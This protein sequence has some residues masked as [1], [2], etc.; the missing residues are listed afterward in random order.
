M[1]L[2]YIKLAGF[3]S[4]VDPTTIKFLG[5]LVSIL[6]PNGCGKSNIIDAIRWVM[7]ESSAK[8]LR[9]ESI[10]DVIFNGSATRSPVG[11]ASIELLFDNQQGKITGEFS[12]YNEIS[13]KRVL[14]R[15]GQSLYYL[16]KSRC[17]RK[18]VKE[19]FLGT[20]LGPRS[21][22]I[23]EQGTISR[24]IEAKPEEVRIYIE[25]AAGVSKY[26]ERRKETENRIKQTRENLSRLDDICSELDKQLSRLQRQARTAKN[27]S[28]LKQEERL[29]QAQLSALRWRNYDIELKEQQLLLSQQETAL[30]NK[31]L[32]ANTLEAKI[33]TSHLNLAS[34]NQH[35]N[36]AQGEF[37]QLEADISKL[38]QN[39][40]NLKERQRQQQKSLK[41]AQEN[42]YKTQAHLEEDEQKYL[43]L[44]TE[45]ASI[46]PDFAQAKEQCLSLENEWKKNEQHYISWKNKWQKK[47]QVIQQQTHTLQLEKTNSRHIEQQLEQL[48]NRSNKLNIELSSLSYES[49]KHEIETLTIEIT[50]LDQQLEQHQLELNQQETTLEQLVKQYEQQTTD[51]AQLKQQ[52]QQYQSKL[53]ALEQMQLALSNDNQA[54]AK[55]WLSKQNLWDKQR[56]LQNLEV[57]ENYEELVETVLIDYLQAFYLSSTDYQLVC[58]EL[59][60]LSQTS[61][62][63]LNFNFCLVEN[64]AVLQSQCFANNKIN[65]PRLSEFINAE[66]VA[67]E[68][69]AYIYVASDLSIALA[70]QDFLQINEW[71]ITQDGFCVGHCWLKNIASDPQHNG[72]IQREKDIKQLNQSINS[73][74]EIL[75]Q[76]QLVVAELAENKKNKQQQFKLAQDEL[77]RLQKQKDQHTSTLHSK[78][79]IIEQSKKRVNNINHEQQELTVQIDK[80]QQKQQ[81]L[82]NKIAEIA[83]SLTDLE[84]EKNSLQQ[85]SY[86]NKQQLNE[87]KNKLEQQQKQKHQIEIKL[88]SVQSELR[89]IEPSIE[90]IRA[91]LTEQKLYCEKLAEDEAPAEQAI[92]SLQVELDQHL[93]KKI[94]ENKKFVDAKEVVENQH[95]LCRKLEG[96]RNENEQQ[97][98]TIREKCEKLRLHYQELQLK[99]QAQF[100]LIQEADFELSQLFLQ[101][102]E[103]AKEL[104]WQTKLQQLANKINSLGTINLAAIA[105]YDEQK[106]RK[107]YLDEQNQDLQDALAT[108]EQAMGKI[109]RET[110][111]RFKETFDKINQNMQDLFPRLFNGGHSYLELTGDNLLDTGVTIMARPPGKRNNSIHLLSGGE[112]ALTAVAFVFA[113]FTL[114]PAPFCLLDEVDAPLDEANVGRFCQL[115]KEMSKTIQFIFITHNKTSMEMSD[116]LC[117]VTMKEPGV[118]RI[119]EV[120]LQKAVA[121]ID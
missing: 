75:E 13:V 51:I 25:E 62:S 80:M 19:L 8:N 111:T 119:V 92:K 5:N 49:E 57:V 35:L 117:G 94:S 76:K 11:Q 105:E 84:Q 73:K 54:D 26:K 42:Y 81:V 100:E 23:I 37:Y 43:R 32:L 87:S 66:S 115:L 38:E 48:H 89:A 110:S 24:L 79:L 22:S 114:N 98:Q 18:D 31:S 12:Q 104:E 36:Q 45:L 108:L 44:K 118:S 70:N 58:D 52:Q 88:K 3:K 65:L 55:Q 99:Q 46:E 74:A 1:H 53:Y 82:L 113:I 106:E 63:A 30:E 15:D 59:K 47:Q 20:G 6:G 39:I 121:L 83:D 77:Y 68:L 56:L 95:L 116:F 120:D 67:K 97:R 34:A 78:K 10:S 14:Q 71:I 61:T 86:T 9:G 41:L 33:E 85:D 103:H 29:C 17:R 69:L 7:G 107:K 40:E 102:P 21:Y 2:K 72:F 91:Q 109:D 93:L 27:Y 96:E 64:K 28:L 16:N 50:S 90:R 112:K 101:I 4:F 60:N